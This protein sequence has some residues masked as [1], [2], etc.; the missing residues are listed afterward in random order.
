MKLKP[1]Y[2]GLVIIILL[3]LTAS[4]AFG[5]G[6]AGTVTGGT[7]AACLDPATNSNT[8]VKIGGKV[9]APGGL[10]RVPTGTTCLAAETTLNLN[11]YVKTI[12]VSPGLNNIISGTNLQ[13]AMTAATSGTLIKVEPGTYDLGTT[14]LKMKTGVDLE[15]SGEGLTTITS[16]VGGSSYPLISGTVVIT[17][18]SE[19]RFLTIANTGTSTY[20]AGV[21]GNGV[22]NTSKL[23]N[24]TAKI[25][26]S[27]SVNLA[28][29]ITNSASPIIQNSTI[30]STGGSSSNSGIYN[31]NASSPTIQNSTI[32]AS[33][34][35]NTSG[36]FIDSSSPTIQN[37]TI[38]AS[39]GTNN[40]GIQSQTSSTITIQNSTVNVTPSA[41]YYS[42]RNLGGSTARVGASQ[43]GTGV[44]G[45]GFTCV[46]VYSSSFVALNSSCG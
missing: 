7:F 27:G 24:V 11:S 42:I 32:S 10:V 45:V 16:Q 20:N 43:L 33:G 21:Y 30:S 14:T 41:F 26:G 5:V 2:L 22:N 6:N 19:I 46:G 35:T 28:I 31:S 12:L 1:F 15:G 25:S 9:V 36:I 8:S 39:G 29:F 17:S 3:G 44:F 4:S 23:T 40:L 18:S 37:S 34:G 38:S 13:N